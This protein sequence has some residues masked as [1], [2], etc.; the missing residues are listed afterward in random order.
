MDL[1]KAYHTFAKTFFPEV[2]RIADRFHVNRYVT[3]A[4]QNVR[5]SL[6]KNL[7]PFAKKELKQFFTRKPQHYKET[8]LLEC[9]LEW[10]MY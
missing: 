9:N 6:Q 8:I 3:D 5:R 1:A 4:I 10:I 2:I 7:A